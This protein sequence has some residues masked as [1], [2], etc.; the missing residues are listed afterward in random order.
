VLLISGSTVDFRAPEIDAVGR[1]AFGL[2]SV[3]PA[4]TKPFFVI[5]GKNKP[6]L[7]A[8][9]EAL[10]RSGLDN[11][12]RLIVRSS[13][14]DEGLGAKGA[15]ESGECVPSGIEPEINR[16]IAHTQVGGAV[17][18]VVQE[19]IEQRAKGHLS[20]ERRVAKD[21]R[22]WVVEFEASE[23]HGGET[24]RI[25]LRR[26]RDNRRPAEELLNCGHR[27]MVVDRLRAVAGWT[28]DRVIRV[29]FEWV[30]DGHA[31]YIV[32]ADACDEVV[33]GIDPHTS[34]R[35]AIGFNASGMMLTSFRVANSADYRKYRKLANVKLY[36][37]LGYTTPPFY[38]FDSADEV[39]G[40][41][42]GR[43]I[44]SE[45]QA[46]LR[47][48]TRA[49]LV[50][51]TDGTNIPGHL[52]EMLPRS[53][54]LR[55]PEAAE[56]WLRE[57]FSN[58]ASAANE[59]GERLLD[60][61]LCLIA[62][63]FVP[64]VASAWC[65]ALPDQRRVRIESLWGIPEGLYWYAYDVYDVDTTAAG[66]AKMNQRP[67]DLPF[68]IR[69]RYKEHF[70]APDSDGCWVVQ[71]T[72]DKADWPRSIA[73]TEWI[74]EVAWTTRCIA[75]SENKPVVV[76]WLIDTAGT[77]TP[78]RVLPWYHQ[79]WKH[80]GKLYKASPRK[81]FDR[82]SEVVVRSHADWMQ[83]RAAIDR[84][85]SLSRIKV[86]PREPEPMLRWHSRSSRRLEATRF[87]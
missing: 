26:W 86:D 71:K 10:R 13:G 20:N 76:M 2:A 16:L 29:H 31:V 80:E 52:R 1:K 46:D 9:K 81:K 64:A 58:K 48:L 67:G 57:T 7:S 60:Y 38:V 39:R 74:Q 21:K 12:R 11:A 55:S 37:E 54:E 30:W 28:Y 35:T 69:Q 6:E 75:S 87:K 49:G 17:H 50:I 14:V 33:Q 15:L 51:R 44:S 84:G 47:T 61:Q 43:A 63:H 65:Q 85:E 41:A 23:S 40:I 19:A 59:K 42:E 34:V 77:S 68:R 36:G 24:H 82:S 53:D 4:W 79:E 73:R 66:V 83:I 62:H 3:P 27:E 25:P 8:L 5:D 72:T 78:H 45:V 32:Q 22:D 70:V 18:W 56:K